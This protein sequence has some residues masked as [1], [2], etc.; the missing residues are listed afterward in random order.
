MYDVSFKIDVF[1][2]FSIYP[3]DVFWILFFHPCFQSSKLKSLQP[4]KSAVFLPCSI[5]L[6][7]APSSFG[8][9]QFYHLLQ[10]GLLL[11]NCLSMYKW[12]LLIVSI[13][14]I[15]L[16]HLQLSQNWMYNYGGT[17][18]YKAIFCGD[19]PLHRPYIGLIYGRYLHFRILKFPLT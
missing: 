12:R 11:P 13:S 18:P 16:S 9:P 5:S 19:I 3:R 6:Y 7:S 10:K 2:L 17:V 1:C 14:Q 4:H 8:V 15:T